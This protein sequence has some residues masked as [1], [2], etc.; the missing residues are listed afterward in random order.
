MV[1]RVHAQLVI[2]PSQWLVTFQ[3]YFWI[4][5]LE[6]ICASQLSVT[7]VKGFCGGGFL[8]WGT[9]YYFW[10]HLRILASSSLTCRFEQ[11]TLA[12]FAGVVYKTPFGALAKEFFIDVNSESRCQS[13]LPHPSYPSASI[14]AWR[15]RL[16]G[17]FIRMVP[18]P[19]AVARSLTMNGVDRFQNTF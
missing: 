6:Y 3:Q 14:L 9:P 19:A 12:R 4:T 15:L 10:C 11:A 17:V 13:S 7:V 1:P 8:F 5:L 16:S 18:T 2:V